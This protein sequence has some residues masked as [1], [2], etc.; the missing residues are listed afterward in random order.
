MTQVF[1]DELASLNDVWYQFLLPKSLVSS[2]VAQ[3]MYQDGIQ[4]EGIL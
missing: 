4:K 3:L 1:R 2:K